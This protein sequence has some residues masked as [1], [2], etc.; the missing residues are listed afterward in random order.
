MYQA[1]WL[2][3]M[4]V[5]GFVITGCKGPEETNSTTPL[6]GTV[7]ITGTAQVG[8][9]LTAD[10][11]SLGGSGTISY[12]WKRGTANIGTNSG[13]YTVQSADK[14]YTIT[15]TVTRH[16]YSG[17]VT[18]DP[19]SAVTDSS[20][21]PIT[22]TVRYDKN[23]ADATGTTA[24]STHIYNVEKA[25][26]ANGYTRT[27]Y[28]FVGWNTQAN[29][30]GTGYTNS[31]YVKNLTSTE[32]TVFTL[33]AVWL[34]HDEADFGTGANTNTFNVSTTAEWDAAVSTIVGGGNDKNYIIN[35][36]ADFSVTGLTGLPTGYSF[37]SVSGVTVSLRGPDRT[38]SLSGNGSILSIHN[39]Q[40]VILR[41]LTLR[42]HDANDSCMIHVGDMSTIFYGG[43]GSNGTFTMHS[44]EISGNTT[45]SF[46]GGGVNVYNRGIFTMNGGE[47]SGNTTTTPFI[48]DNGGVTVGD[49]GIFTMNG[50]EISGNTTT[51]HGGGVKVE[52]RGTFT[53]N[54]GEIS[55][56]TALYGGGVYSNSSGTFTMNGGEISGNTALY[57]GGGGVY[58]NSSGTF[59]MNGGVISGN[60]SYGRGVVT[61]YGT[62]TMNGGEIS[63]NT[64][65]DDDGGG[66]VH[67]YEGLFTMNGGVITDNYLGVFV[68]YGTFTMHS[69]KITGNNTYGGVEVDRGLFTMNG[70]EIS[71]NTA[72]D[73]GG[74]AVNGE[75]FF[76]MNGGEITGNTAALGGGGVAMNGGSFAMKGGKI[77]GNTTAGDGGGVYVYDGFF[78][79]NGGEISGNTA[80]DGGGVYV[81]D[82]FFSMNGGEISG[83]TASDK[84][85]GVYVDENS[86]L[87]MV[88]GTIYGSNADVSLRNTASSGSAL[89]VGG[90][91]WWDWGAEYGT[92]SDDEWESNGDL[93]STEDTIRVLNGKLQ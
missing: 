34:T 26:T 1:F 67:V 72:D 75:G 91:Q 5:T 76:L 90:D 15:V 43:G 21:L 56:N 63:G 50:G 16:G 31:R 84:G 20:L 38:L 28:T 9:T 39:L 7:S 35:V 78:S 44:G 59:T 69:G 13:T 55:G 89:Y 81:Y 53:M 47:I 58:S 85:G 10:T 33:Y 30:G 86:R 14:G 11:G 32:G 37:G 49:G 48:S 29:G 77:S 27:D 8:Q 3:V 4:V 2:A 87:Y 60:T 52:S 68:N 42:G 57:G 12:Q 71:G 40:T 65:D 25:L 22:Y 19:T 18:S 88:T 74:V 70:G 61:V 62:F 23:A 92:F 93:E 82:G 66:G 6:T 54:G 51:S 80:D 83:N 45:T 64:A 36:T 24:D 41:D 17:S 46:G 79:M 73:G